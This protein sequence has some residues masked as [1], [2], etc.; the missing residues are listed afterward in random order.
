MQ[1]KNI[2]QHFTGTFNID[3]E[4]IT[5]ELIYNKEKG[6]T[7]LNLIKQLTDVP[8]GRNY[9]NLDVITGVLNSG[10]TVTLFHNR[11]IK[12]HT[13]GFQTQQLIF[14]ADYSIW[15]KRDANIGVQGVQTR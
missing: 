8:I 7:M 14:V 12:N 4:K 5:G 9:P 3:G 10:T 6:V 13:Q 1:N 2:D 11:C 15:S